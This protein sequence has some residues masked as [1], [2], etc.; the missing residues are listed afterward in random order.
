[1]STPLLQ[2]STCVLLTP[3][4]NFEAFGYEAETKYTTMAEDKTHL[5]WYLFRGFKMKLYE[6]KV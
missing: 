5:G 3:E 4:K 2:T 6:T 1:M